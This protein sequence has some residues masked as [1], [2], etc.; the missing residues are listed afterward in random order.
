MN[1]KFTAGACNLVLYLKALPQLRG[2]SSGF[3]HDF[4][5]VDGAEFPVLHY[6]LSADDSGCNSRRVRC[7]TK[8][9]S[10]ILYNIRKGSNYVLIN[11]QTVVNGGKLCPTAAGKVLHKNGLA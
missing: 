7:S 4:F 6:D 10:S 5:F 11:G 3:G 1:P 9:H 8:E 2:R